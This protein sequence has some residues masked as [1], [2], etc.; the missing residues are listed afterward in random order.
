MS[1][2]P[3][4]KGWFQRIFL[5]GCGHLRTCQ[6]CLLNWC[7]RLGNACVHPL[8]N[9]CLKSVEEERCETSHLQ[10]H[11]HFRDQHTDVV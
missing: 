10:E 5:G 1:T 11:L 4:F 7:G 9:R 8:D 3:V 6:V 2:F